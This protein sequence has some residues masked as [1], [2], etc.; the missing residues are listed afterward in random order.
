MERKELK[1]Q[2]KIVLKKHYI[3]LM[4]T[5][6]VAAF[7]GS[8][9]ALSISVS[10]L[11]SNMTE[12]T[13]EL[14]DDYIENRL[15]EV[16]NENERKLKEIENSETDKGKMLGRTNGV[17]SSIINM[18]GTK[19]IYF[20]VIKGLES[21][22]ASKTVALALLII[23]SFLIQFIIWFF[24]INIF[25]VI[26]R[27]I[28]L[29]SRIYKTVPKERFIFLQKTRTWLKVAKTMFLTSLY[30]TLWYFTIIGGIIKSY[31]YR[32]VPYIVAENPSIPSQK[33]I[34]LSRYMMKGHKW[35]M[36]K[37]DLSF[38]LWNI[39]G[40]ITWGLSDVFFTNLYKVASET[41]YYAYLRKLAIDN[42]INDIENLN[43]IYLYEKA[44]TETL[45][46][47]YKDVVDEKE[48]KEVYPNK[49]KGI[50]GFFEN[51][52]GINLSSKEEEEKHEKE[53]VKKIKLKKSKDELKGDSYPERLFTIKIKDKKKRIEII[54]YMRRYSITNLIFLF[55][56]LSFIGWIW[57]VSL[58]LITLG[59]FINRGALHGPWL[60]IYGFGGIIILLV[61]Y[62]FRSKV[63]NHLALSAILCGFL[64]Y[65]SS[66]AL[67]M[68]YGQKWWD[69]SGY[70]INLN[71]RICAEGLL[72][73][74]L[75]GMFIVYILAPYMDNLLRKLNKKV[76]ILLCMILLLV[77]SIDMIYSHNNPNAGE[78][79]T[80]YSYINK[81]ET[82]KILG[83][84]EQKNEFY[85]LYDCIYTN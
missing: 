61:L 21:L 77:F 6:L 12:S 33:A 13:I 55:F 83:K 81:N 4:I 45:K 38:I 37:F 63:I 25:N 9:F 29:E 17:F 42:K 23:A 18:F 19:N 1:K 46:E 58:H 22:H 76:A 32:L 71:G 27:R 7:I 26:T 24:F 36:F 3:L 66:L 82:N 14:S 79:I 84:T 35:E 40:I 54:N 8:E 16:E 70:F 74:A 5:C 80:D 43:D 65:F 62:K 47:A 2:A 31:S 64:E 59:K 69:Y 49:S 15:E 85:F 34:T 56:I 41:E 50:K 72:V 28:F 20:K 68:T 53:I 44:D 57:E 60:P 78:G 52:L 30:H 48:K 75:G 73:F 67:E 11:Q 10:S 51:I 39:L